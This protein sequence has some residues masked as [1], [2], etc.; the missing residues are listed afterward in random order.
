MRW[1]CWETSKNDTACNICFNDFFFVKWLGCSH[2]TEI[3]Y[4]LAGSAGDHFDAIRQLMTFFLRLETS[5]RLNLA[6]CWKWNVQPVW[7]ALA[8]KIC[9]NTK[10]DEYFY[11]LNIQNIQS[12]FPGGSLVL[13]SCFFVVVVAIIR[14]SR[15]NSA[16][17]SKVFELYFFFFL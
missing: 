5:L 1:Q 15:L 6:E 11:L 4:H 14:F 12:L 9:A 8:A 17:L 10:Y 16:L 2:Q 13:S 3:W 7:W